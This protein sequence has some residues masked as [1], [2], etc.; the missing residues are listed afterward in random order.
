MIVRALTTFKADHHMAPGRFNIMDLKGVQIILDYGHNAAAMKALMEGVE[1]LGKRR[2]V[3]VL[4]LPG[5]RRDEDIEETVRATIP[6]VST[7]ILHD[8]KDDRRGREES[9]VPKL[10]QRALPSDAH[11][12]IAADQRAGIFRAWEML[13]PGD[14]L[15]VTADLVDDTIQMLRALVDTVSEDSA[16]DIPLMRS[17]IEER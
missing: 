2:T 4:G 12:E 1:A 14:R 3:M 16:C 17:L 8:L 15:I 6:Y 13:K 5:D 9:E 7:Y 10:M 11:S